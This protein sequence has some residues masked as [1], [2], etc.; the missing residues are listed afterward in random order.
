MIP[1]INVVVAASRADHV[2]H[3]VAIGW[4]NAAIAEC[5]RGG[6]IE[7]LPQ[8]A[9]G[10]LRLVTNR[11]V[12]VQPTPT[13]DALAFIDALLDTPGVELAESGREWP[14]LRQLCLEHSLAGNDIP[15]AWIAAAVQSLRR[16][17]VTFD[18]GFSRLLDDTYLTV[19]PPASR[20]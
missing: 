7:L 4:L 16:Q 13:R 5:A 20:H 6:S 19:L 11:R 17:L 1:D 10:F 9:A 14:A 18:G 15:D 12:F 3:D 2:H 8:V